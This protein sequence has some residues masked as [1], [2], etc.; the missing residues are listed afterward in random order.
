MLLMALLVTA[1][2]PFTLADTVVYDSM[3]TIKIKVE[4]LLA[5][6]TLVCKRASQGLS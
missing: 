1:C 3:Q 2:Y 6:S 5:Y 4:A